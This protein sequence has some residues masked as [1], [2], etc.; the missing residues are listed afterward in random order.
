M[1]LHFKP[2]K[3]RSLSIC[4]GSPKNV[5]FVLKSSE[6]LTVHIESVHD[7]PHTFLGATVT[8]TNTAQ[9]YY[10][11]FRKI[12]SD[13]LTNIDNS[14]VRGEHKLAIYER[15]A[16]PSMRYHLSIHDL[17][18]THL[19]GLDKVARM[20]IK[21]WLKYPT[22]G[23]TDVG[24]FHPYLL[25]V[26]QPSHLYYEGHASNLL[27]MKTKGDITVNKCISSKLERESQWKRKSST[28]VKSNQIVA[29]I[30]DN[31]STISRSEGNMYKNGIG[32]A[33]R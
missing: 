14:R 29:P 5:S 26:K 31:M 25:N 10:Q 27:L 28:A 13:K 30:V 32:K 8:Y 24:I 33:K 20:F 18:K 1:G 12:L 15:H 17:N 19:D 6:K 11:Q 4:G 16:L 2:S 9:E 23:V 22:R 3:C 21:M 7:N